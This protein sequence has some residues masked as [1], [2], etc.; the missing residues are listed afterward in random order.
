MKNV[1]SKKISSILIICLLLALLMTAC[2]NKTGVDTNATNAPTA[3]V[4]PS[5]TPRT[6]VE[7][8]TPFDWMV[9]GE[10]IEKNLSKI[11]EISEARVVVNGQSALVAVKFNPAYKGE[12][13]DRI[14]EMI[15]N[16]ITKADGNIENIVVT[17]DDN[18]VNSIYTV[19]DRM[20]A[21]ESMNTLRTDIEDL[22]RKLTGRV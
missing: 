1:N 19:S 18:D 17:T 9:N 10:A 14:R 20:R 13:T 4:S 16:E 7:A 11:S 2:M 8:T 12:L 21:G 3:S 5:V 22:F 15:A 6:T